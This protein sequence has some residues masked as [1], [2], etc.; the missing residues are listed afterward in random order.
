[1]I[2]IYIFF[3]YREIQTD[4]VYVH[5]YIQKEEKYYL[6]R[7]NNIYGAVQCIV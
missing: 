4:R 7:K 2:H 6:W 3:I 5:I 1:M